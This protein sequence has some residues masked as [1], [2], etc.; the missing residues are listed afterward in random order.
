MGNTG[1]R[2]R[3][4]GEDA[5]ID[6]VAKGLGSTDSLVVGVGDD[7]AVLKR[8]SS[9]YLTLFKTDC[10]IENV[11]FL[12]DA[13]PVKVGWK[14][15]ARVISDVAAM[16]GFPEAALVT[17]ALHPAT[18]VDWVRG[19]YRG[20]RKAEREFN[21]AVVGGETSSTSRKA[22]NVVSVSM[23]GYVEEDRCVLRSTAC[24]GDG[25]FVTGRLGGSLAGRHLSFRP[26]LKEAR[27]LSEHFKPSAMMDLSDGVASDLPRLASASEL[28]FELQSS[29]IPRAKDCSVEQALND[30][31][32]YE[33]LF[34]IDMG[35]V[36]SLH[37]EW[38]NVFPRLKLSRIGTM[39]P[40]GKKIPVG[41][42][43]HFVSGSS[44]SL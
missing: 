15:M 39:T 17:I 9:G 43:R 25:I 11:H 16:G 6:L 2:V 7:C 28:G 21:F 4:L 12:P 24:A 10:V 22:T 27:W 30:G 38:K 37:R 31:E 8:S 13:D 29:A 41:G 34:T 3:D 44:D 19:L 26:R 40:S 36:E 42:W 35:N 18:E 5:L 32:D 1:R 23:L 14:S 33:L 20:I